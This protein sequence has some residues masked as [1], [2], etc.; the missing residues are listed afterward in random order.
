MASS[1]S[2]PP[3]LYFAYGSNLSLTQ[4]RH[5][6]PTATYD[7]LA[8]LK[9]WKWIIGER[10]YANVV[11]AKSRTEG[12]VRG[13]KGD[14]G[15][16]E[17]GKGKKEE[18]YEGDRV[19][20]MVYLLQDEDER[21]LDRAEGVPWAYEKVLLEVEILPGGEGEGTRKEGEEQEGRGGK[22]VD[23]LVY[24]DFKR[25]G[26]GVCREEYVARMNR[27]IKDA[28]QKGMPQKYV[29]D[30]LR[31]WVRDEDLPKDGEV[32]DPFLHGDS[33]GPVGVKR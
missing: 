26:E 15:S 1:S 24:V 22:K 20:G 29:D 27:G 6:C 33:E 3:H 21:I 13:G 25:L 31:K 12:L 19:F 7:S 8:V 11:Q 5:R 10:G 2:S 23:V 14:G 18:E 9:G 28:V 30:V 32:E 16:E 4:M 17:D